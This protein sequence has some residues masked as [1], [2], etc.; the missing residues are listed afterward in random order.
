VCWPY[1]KRDIFR[2]TP[3]AISAFTIYPDS[4]PATLLL[5]KIFLFFD[6]IPIQEVPNGKI[7]QNVPTLLP[8]GSFRSVGSP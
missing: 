1:C 6:I 5:K 8:I 4:K 7:P 2:I 3:E